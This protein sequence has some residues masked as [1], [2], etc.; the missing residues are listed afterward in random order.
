MWIEGAALGRYG[1]AE[2]GYSRFHAGPLIEPSLVSG[3]FGERPE[4]IVGAQV[5]GTL[6]GVEPVTVVP[7]YAVETQGQ[8]R[9]EQR[10][11]QKIRPPQQTPGGESSQECFARRGPAHQPPWVTMK[12][13]SRGRQYGTSIPTRCRTNPKS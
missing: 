6:V 12:S 2:I 7:I 3:L 13:G 4:H 8:R 5:K 10:W 9:Q 11:Q 1:G